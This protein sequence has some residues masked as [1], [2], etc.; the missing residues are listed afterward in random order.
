LKPLAT[1]DPT[2]PHG[3][4]VRATLGPVADPATGRTAWQASGELTKGQVDTFQ[5]I[6]FPLKPP[7]DLAQADGVVVDSWVP[8]GQKTPTS[9]LVILHEEG[10]GDFLAQTG[11]SLGTPGPVRSILPL[12]RFQLAGW[13]KD[14]NGI[15]DAGRVAAVRIGWGGYLGA[16]GET[17]RFRVAPPQI[18]LTRPPAP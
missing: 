8:A 15:L 4:F 17:V 6:E 18:A 11:R 7:A 12:T 16:E 13:A 2:T 5:F 9:L 1:A 10:G 3:A 14:D